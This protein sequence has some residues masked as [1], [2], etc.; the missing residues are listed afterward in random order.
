MVRNALIALG[1]SGLPHLAPHALALL[2]DSDPMVRGAAVWAAGQV[3]PCSLADYAEAAL[4]CEDDLT[5][6]EEWSHALA[7]VLGD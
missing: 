3:S 2:S 4:A 1:N 7:Q 5:V 6:R